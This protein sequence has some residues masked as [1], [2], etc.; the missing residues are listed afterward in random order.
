M[1][2]YSELKRNLSN[3]QYD[4]NRL[5]EKGVDSWNLKGGDYA[6]KSKHLSELKAQ[7]AA[8]TKE[9]ADL[10][11]E[12]TDELKNSNAEQN[13]KAISDAEAKV[14]DVQDEIRKLLKK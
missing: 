14:S 6:K 1:E 8:L 4:L 5:K 13:A 3:A 12:V 2:R 7:L 9:I 11:L 10:E